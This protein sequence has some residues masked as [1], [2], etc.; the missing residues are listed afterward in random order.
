ML[1]WMLTTLGA[2][3]STTGAKLDIHPQDGAAVPVAALVPVVMAGAVMGVLAG[4][5][6]AVAVVTAVSTT[7]GVPGAV[8]LVPGS[9]GSAQTAGA[10]LQKTNPAANASAVA[11]RVILFI[12]MEICR[13][14]IAAH[15]VRRG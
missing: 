1:V 4:V 8:L 14:R 7:I 13:G 2:T 15:A 5:A 10:P 6:V 9:V 11:A 3:C 12:K